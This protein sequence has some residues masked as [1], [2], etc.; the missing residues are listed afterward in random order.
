MLLN[1]KKK[2]NEI[3][4]YITPDILVNYNVN[5][6]ESFDIKNILSIIKKN[7]EVIKNNID[8]ESDETLIGASQ[9]IF[10]PLLLNI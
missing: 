1:E 6:F 4:K 10:D 8:K 2:Y 5:F 7:P 3:Y 9:M